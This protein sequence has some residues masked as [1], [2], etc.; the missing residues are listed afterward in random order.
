[1]P[2]VLLL[3]QRPMTLSRREAETWF[4]GEIDRLCADAA[5]Q[6]AGVARVTNIHEDHP[7]GWDWLVRLRLA[8][9][10]DSEDRHH[11]SELLLDLRLLRMH[12]A[13]VFG[14]ATTVIRDEQRA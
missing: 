6:G 13:V 14:R 10:G 4:R 7:A 1:M 5:V 2:R 3:C 9:V 12:P 11:L 8:D